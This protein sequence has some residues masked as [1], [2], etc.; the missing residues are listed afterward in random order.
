MTNSV[1]TGGVF[2]AYLLMMAMVLIVGVVVYAISA[3]F[4]SK[5]FD[6]AG[7][8]GK[9]R[10]WVPVYNTMVM[11]KLADLS[12]WIVLYLVGAG[13]VLSVIG[14]GF[15]GSLAFFAVSFVVAHRIGQKLGAEPAMVVLWIIPLI[16]LIVMGSNRNQWINAVAPAPWAG[17]SFLEDRTSWDGVPS[18]AAPPPVQASPAGA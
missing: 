8:E 1:A 10:A 6:K 2:A 18:Q 11:F 17:N 15:L 5:V 4:L 9:W 13:L 12:P 7:V 14:I 3:Y 16:W